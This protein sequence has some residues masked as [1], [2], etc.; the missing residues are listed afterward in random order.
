[1]MQSKNYLDSCTV[2]C[3]SIF[4]CISYMDAYD[5]DTF[6]WIQSFWRSVFHSFFGKPAGRLLSPQAKILAI[7]EV[8]SWV[9]GCKYNMNVNFQ[10]LSN[11]LTFFSFRF[12]IKGSS[13]WSK[14]WKTRHGITGSKGNATVK[15][16]EPR[17]FN[18]DY[19]EA[20]LL[21][22]SSIRRGNFHSTVLQFSSVGSAIWI[23]GSRS[24]RENF[25]REN[26][27]SETTGFSLGGGS[28]CLSC[29]GDP[30]SCESLDGY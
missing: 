9:A 19:C 30:V 18:I 6:W 28:F 11:V 22:S 2:L 10:M 29:S 26:K 23:F 14:P 24:L 13:T 21:G 12:L 3:A 20:W 25:A 4:K 27:P 15:A 17:R 1:M 7:A 16:P 8:G 5:K